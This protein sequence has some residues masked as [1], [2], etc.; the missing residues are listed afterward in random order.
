MQEQAAAALGSLAASSAPNCA[1]MEEAGALPALVQLLDSGSSMAQD[2]AAAALSSLAAGSVSIAAKIAE[3]GGLKAFVKALG[4]TKRTVH[5]A[6]AAVLDAQAAS[7]SQARA[8]IVAAG[9]VPALVQLLRNRNTSQDVH[10]LATAALDSLTADNHEEAA[11]VA[12]AAVAAAGGIPALVDM[13]GSD[14][15]RGKVHATAVLR[16]IAAATLSM[17]QPRIAMQAAQTAVLSLEQH[18]KAAAV[19]EG[20][21]RTLQ[22]PGACFFLGTGCRR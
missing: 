8:D 4:N 14:S 12:A 6:A 20:I 19:L 17:E 21:E 3:S 10:C 15:G 1:A 2:H 13:Q 22:V 5:R 7:S 16:S 18:Q 11:A 9:G